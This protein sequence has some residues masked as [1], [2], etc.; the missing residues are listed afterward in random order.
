MLDSSKISGKGSCDMG[1]PGVEFPAKLRGALLMALQIT[2]VKNVT[3]LNLEGPHLSVD[4]D[5]GLRGALE[6]LRKDSFEHVVINMQNV[7]FMDS[8][9]MGIF[10]SGR[11][12]L[13]NKCEICICEALPGIESILMHAK[14]DHIIT[15][16][17][18]LGAALKSLGLD[19]S[20]LS[21]AGS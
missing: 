2:R 1:G 11:M 21:E 9:G 7:E 15:L 3:I 17:D 18:S 8:V 20:D 19:A 12:L 6:Q 4:D 5:Q 14:L 10:I 13:R 16:H